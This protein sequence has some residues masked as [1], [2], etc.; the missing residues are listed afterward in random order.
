[1]NT[2]VLEYDA[3]MS[4]AQAGVEAERKN[5]QPTGYAW[6]KASASL[7][8]IVIA[9]ASEMYSMTV[10]LHA[11]FPALSDGTDL[12]HDMMSMRYGIVAAL[13]LGHIVLHKSASEG[14]LLRRIAGR[15]RVLP[16]VAI[17][18]GM[19]GFMFAAMSQATGDGQGGLAGI[20]IGTACGGLF[21]MSFLACNALV[22]KFLPS[23]RAVLAGRAARKE[24]AEIE[25]IMAA[26]DDCQAE[27]PA[28]ERNVSARLQPDYIAREVAAEAAAVVG[29]VAAE[30]HGLHAMRAAI[31]DD[32]H[33][34]DHFD[35]PDMPVVLSAQLQADLKKYDFG[36]FLNLLKNKEA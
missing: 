27:I 5:L 26:A 10:A 22:G 14:G 15:F 31:G 17:L 9:C 6:F 30:A 4:R 24:I 19:A 21:S 7:I 36:F 29:R 8:G 18:G 28:L 13:G 1:M 12:G 2:T 11:E 16:A 32:V 34:D 25:A 20:A 23:L 33:P 35:L 3:V